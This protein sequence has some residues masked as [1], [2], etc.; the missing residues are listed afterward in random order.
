VKDVEGTVAGHSEQGKGANSGLYG[1]DDRGGRERTLRLAW[2][3]RQV[4]E[5]LSYL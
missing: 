1:Q 3:K 4:F 2:T 5:A